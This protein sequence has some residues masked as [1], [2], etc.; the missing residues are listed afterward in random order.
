MAVVM[1]NSVRVLEPNPGCEAGLQAL[2][3]NPRSA[4]CCS[5][6]NFGFG[7]FAHAHD[8]RAC[9]CNGSTAAGKST[10]SDLQSDSITAA[11]VKLRACACAARCSAVAGLQP[12]ARAP[13]PPRPWRPSPRCRSPWRPAIS[14]RHLTIWPT[15]PVAACNRGA[16]ASQAD[17]ADQAYRGSWGVS[18]RRG[19]QRPPATSRIVPVV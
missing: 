1:T 8:A 13:A 6:A 18:R 15:P 2:Q 12:A 5:S 7:H 17:G 3:W 19:R 4:Y 11:P 9:G 16:E 14:P 10:C